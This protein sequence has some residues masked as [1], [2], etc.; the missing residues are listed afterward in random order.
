MNKELTNNVNNDVTDINLS[1]TA[2]KRF[3][4]NGDDSKI[5][6]LNTSDMNVLAR[7]KEVYPKLNSLAAKVDVLEY[8]E[9]AEN[10]QEELEKF[11]E[12]WKEIDNEMRDFVD[13]IFQSNVSEVCADSGSMYD[14]YG[15]KFRFEWIIDTLSEVYEKDMQAEFKKVTKRV[16]KHTS[17]YIK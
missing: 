5:L 10:Q 3:R 4:I 14:P 9:D 8:N 7:L 13:Y 17:K 1:V 11:S 2:K 15:G 16:Q 12:K 6:E